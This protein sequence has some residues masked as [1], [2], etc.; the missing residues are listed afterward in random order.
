MGPWLTPS[1][2]PSTSVFTTRKITA[3][4]ELT[5]RKPRHTPASRRFARPRRSACERRGSDYG[6]KYDAWRD[7]P[8]G[9][10][11]TVTCP[12]NLTSLFPEGV[13]WSALALI[14][15]DMLDKFE[16]KDR[17]DDGEWLPGRGK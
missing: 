12:R 9:R 11:T 7:Y 5:I 8:V 13:P 6:G 4:E 15:E 10:Q 1:P 2:P 14:T 16:P 17:G 3:G